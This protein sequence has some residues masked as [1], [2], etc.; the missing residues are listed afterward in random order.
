M[1]NGYLK[2][3]IKVYCKILF[4]G[5]LNKADSR[6]FWVTS[7]IAPILWIIF[8]LVGVLSFSLYNVTICIF[9]FILTFTNLMGYIKCEKNHN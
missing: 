2:V 7:Y 4:L 8:M 3:W 6:V 9:G 5:N 1:K